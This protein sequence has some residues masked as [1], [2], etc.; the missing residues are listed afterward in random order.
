[1]NPDNNDTSGDDPEDEEEDVE[2]EEPEE[3]KEEEDEQQDTEEIEAKDEEE[4]ELPQPEED[5]SQEDDTTPETRTPPL[6]LRIDLSSMMR[7]INTLQ[8]VQDPL[9][10]ETRK[11]ILK[12]QEKTLEEIQKAITIPAFVDLIQQPAIDP[13]VLK[14][15]QEPLL[16]PTQFEDLTEL[17]EIPEPTINQDILDSLESI[18]DTQLFE[19][20]KTVSALEQIEIE[21]ESAEPVDEFIEHEQETSPELEPEPEPGGFTYLFYNSFA[22]YL[23]QRAQDL[24]DEAVESVSTLAVS[25]GFQDKKDAFFN[26]VNALKDT[27]VV[28]LTEAVRFALRTALTFHGNELIQ[29][30]NTDDENEEDNEDQADDDTEEDEDES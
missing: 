6:D 8:D 7:T 19:L 17:P 26:T 24:P 2:E 16:D 14:E 22:L 18:A 15:L 20:Y 9:P 29:S 3:E 23:L 25:E 27:A 12:Q 10:P 21:Q 30:M 1:M 28:V 5:E 4:T 11:A 13:Q